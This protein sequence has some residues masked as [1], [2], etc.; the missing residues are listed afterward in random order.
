MAKTINK[1]VTKINTIYTWGGLIFLVILTIACVLQVFTRKVL[2]ASMN[3]TEECARYCFLWMV[4]LG[5]SVCVGE[6][7]HASVELL[8]DALKGKAKDWHQLFIYIVMAIF[9]MVFIVQ[10]FNIVSMTLKQLS[11]TLHIPMALIYLTIPVSGIGMILNIINN[12]II[13]VQKIRGK[14]EE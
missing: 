8:H 4:F 3:G 10:G 2:G 11:P 7:S 12:G 1:I 14:E 6:G 9:A 13:L 5:S